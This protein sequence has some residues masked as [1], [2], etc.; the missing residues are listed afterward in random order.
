MT[1]E[2]KKLFLDS[3]YD[4]S[5]FSAEQINEL[6]LGIA[7][8]KTQSYMNPMLSVE[9]MQKARQHKNIKLNI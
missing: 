7:T 3:I 5:D 2:L 9:E 1:L 6:E 4:E 8:N